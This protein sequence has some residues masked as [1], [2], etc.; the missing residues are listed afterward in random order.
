MDA[1]AKSDSWARSGSFGSMGRP[2][3]G[4]AIPTTYQLHPSSA[5]DPNLR[6]LRT[7]LIS[8][9][10]V[11]VVHDHMVVRELTSDMADGQI[12]AAFLQRVTN[13]KV[14]DP[15]LLTARSAR[16]TQVIVGTV[17]HYVENNL[18]VKRDPDRWSAEGI[19]N[20]DITSIVCLLVDLAH[21]LGCPYAFPSNVSVAVIKR[22]QLPDGVKNHTAI[23]KVTSDES[24]Y[25]AQTTAMQATMS[26][27][28]ASTDFGPR[29]AGQQGPD[30]FDK[31]FEMDDKMREVTRLLLDFVNVQLEPLNIRINNLNKLDPAMLVMLIG[32]L[33]EF[34]VPLHL[35]DLNPESTAAKLE[36]ARFAVSLMVELGIDVKKINASE[37][38]KGMQLISRG[39][40]HVLNEVRLSV[41]PASTFQSPPHRRIQAPTRPS[42]HLSPAPSPISEPTVALPKPTARLNR[43]TPDESELLVSLR[44]EDKSWPEVLANFPTRSLKACQQHYFYANRSISAPKYHRWSDEEIE[45]VQLMKLKRGSTEERAEKL[46]RTKRAIDGKLNMLN[47]GHTLGRFNKYEADIV[48]KE[49]WRATEEGGMPRWSWLTKRLGRQPA[50]VRLWAIGAGN[51]L[52]KK[53][54]WGVEEEAR[55]LSAIK[56]L[57]E[58]GETLN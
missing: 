18:D 16:A 52:M 25:L 22:E 3:R 2:A 45:N 36:T 5:A 21:V 20:R 35:Y 4:G 44:T 27:S 41:I 14:I 10:N 48:Q 15:D 30:A 47:F 57:G 53:G 46:N 19:I 12:L 32:C 31:L 9:I 33:G 7:A 55:L 39:P 38:S 28:A 56:Q 11:Y 54:P 6:K 49:I 37:N 58:T 34:F 42:R 43:W 1:L 13:D 8:W 50:S 24:K 29:G 40:S 17:L 26:Q 23:H 51:S